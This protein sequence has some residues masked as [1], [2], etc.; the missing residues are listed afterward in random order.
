M[1]N[2]L[3]DNGLSRVDYQALRDEKSEQF[4][5]EFG[6]DIK[7]SRDSGFGQ[8][9][10]VSTQSEN[11]LV[12]LV[13]A[14]LTAFDPHSARGVLL[15]RL[16]TVMNKRRN[17]AVKSSVTIDVITDANG[18][19]LTA[20]FTISNA[21]GIKF[22]YIDTNLVIAPSSTVQAEFSAVND[23]EI[24]A[25]ENTLTSIETPIFGIVSVNNPLAANVGR[26]IESDAQLRARMLRTSSNANGTITGI[27]TAASEVDGVTFVNVIE[28]NTDSAFA[29][30]QPAHSV[31]II[32]KGGADLDIAETLIT[33]GVAAGIT[34]TKQGDISGINFV[35]ENYTLAST[36]QQFTAHW[37]RPVDV[38]IYCKVTIK[39]LDDYPANGITQ[40][41]ESIS[42]WVENNAQVG[43]AFYSSF[44][45]TAI[46]EV[47]GL[48]IESVFI[49][50]TPLPAEILVDIG[51]ID[52]ANISV[53][54]IEVVEV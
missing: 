43:E 14:L 5:A 16:A 54:D 34:Y 3:D 20:G 45:Y 40:I 29:N 13:S 4:K 25:S 51:V 21:A 42:A 39:K 36:G 35:D 9:I 19:T 15:S 22:N 1:P 23:G 47:G 10:S 53:N 37:A 50:D 18:A 31:F 49:A 11:E 6:Q 24:V 32:I 44:L 30:G 33:R 2:I 27:F 41:K 7:T 26:S 28:N 52:I 17:E 38:R 46:N 12:S 8:L 48:A